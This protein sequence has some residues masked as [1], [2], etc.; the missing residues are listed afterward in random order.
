MPTRTLWLIPNRVLFTEFYGTL[1]IDEL[2]DTNRLARQL[3]TTEGLAPSYYI[4]D[5]SATRRYPNDLLRLRS[6]YRQ[7]VPH[8]VSAIFVVVEN[9]MLR[10]LMA[11]VLPFVPTQVT[12]LSSLTEAF[13]Q[14]VNQD[15]AL[16]LEQL[17]QAYGAFKAV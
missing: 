16:Q 7:P 11:L 3:G 4:L 5:Y 9:L 1:N 12:L 13:E 14:I 6:I 17:E 10:G 8:V 15:E 2:A